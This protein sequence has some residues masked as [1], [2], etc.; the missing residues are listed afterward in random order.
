MIL[1]DR[2]RT[3]LLRAHALTFEWH[4]GQTRKGNDIPYVSH[5]VQVAGAVLEFGGDFDQAIAGLL[6]DALEDAPSV[7][8]RARR[9]RMIAEEFGK[10]VRRIVLD[11]TD[12]LAAD[13][14]D[15]KSPWKERKDR[16]IAQLER[17]GAR[18]LLVA[19][20]DKR[21]NLHALVRDTRSDGRAT[22][23]RFSAGASDQ[24]WYFERILS[25]LGGRI[26]ASLHAELE[27]LLA[28]LRH[29]IDSP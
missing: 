12:T 4:A 10:D 13:S 20:C 19:A 28:E 6:H 1:D 22:L 26:P 21:H 5:L 29:L 2:T 24:L 23:E 9:E 3:R 14:I 7:E 11:C 8:E 27:A 25:T 18:S 17:A 15:D 16:Y